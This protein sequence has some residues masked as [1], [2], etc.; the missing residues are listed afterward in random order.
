MLTIQ[1]DTDR[2]DQVIKSL[3]AVIHQA[4]DKAA[5]EVINDAKLRIQSS[6]PT[7][8]Q[9]KRGSRTHVA[10]APGNAPRPDYGTLMGSLHWERGRKYSRLVMDGVEYGYYLEVAK[11]RPF[12][13]PTL[14]HFA[15]NRFMQLL[16]NEL[17]IV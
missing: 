15:Q 14:E 6:P 2:M 10:S 1:I 7:G 5:E 9:Y 12:F 4:M 11:D 3:P 17:N 16:R 8:R 13:R